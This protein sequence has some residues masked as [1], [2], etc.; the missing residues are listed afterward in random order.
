MQ[1]TELPLRG[2]QQPLLH[3]W[4]LLE[5]RACQPAVQSRCLPRLGRRLTAAALR[6]CP[7]VL[8][9]CRSTAGRC[10]VACKQEKH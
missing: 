9:L 7:A 5:Q 8:L 3:L 10:W 6:R 2:R 1:Q 4:Q